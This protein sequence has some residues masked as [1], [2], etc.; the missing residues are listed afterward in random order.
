MSHIDSRSHTESSPVQSHSMGA[1]RHHVTKPRAPRQQAL[2]SGDRQMHLPRIHPQEADHK[3]GFKCLCLVVLA[4]DLLFQKQV[5]R[6]APNGLL[7]VGCAC[8]IWISQFSWCGLCATQCQLSHF[9]SMDFANAFSNGLGCCRVF[10]GL[11]AH[12]HGVHMSLEASKPLIICLCI[13][14][15]HWYLN[16][17][18]KVPVVVCVVCIINGYSVGTDRTVLF[19]QTCRRSHLAKLAIKVC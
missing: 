1:V 8:A 7:F 12:C 14:S 4:L 13:G 16:C 18:V 9:L 5:V 6:L 10:V 11:C 17:P 2:G 19:G 3:P 15:H